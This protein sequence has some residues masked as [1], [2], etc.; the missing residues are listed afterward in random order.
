M[1]KL[2]MDVRYML[3]LVRSEDKGREKGARYV[4]LCFTEVR[5][6]EKAE[7][8]EQAVKISALQRNG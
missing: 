6:E 4:N 2:K 1:R 3:W 8:R 7:K 5:L